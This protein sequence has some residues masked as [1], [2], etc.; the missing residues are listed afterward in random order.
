MKIDPDAAVA[1]AKSLVKWGQ[2]EM[3]EHHLAVVEALRIELK[4]CV[5]FQFHPFHTPT[6]QAAY[7]LLPKEGDLNGQE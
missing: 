3:A 2:D 5:C 1:R 6:C 7:E 4:K